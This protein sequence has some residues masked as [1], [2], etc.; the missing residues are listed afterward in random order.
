[1][2]CNIF[3]YIGGSDE[4]CKIFDL[5]NRVEHGQ[6]MHHEVNEPILSYQFFSSSRAVDP[7]SFFTD[8]A[9]LRNPGPALQNGDVTFF[10][11]LVKITVPPYRTVPLPFV[12]FAV[13][14]PLSS[15]KKIAHGAGPNLL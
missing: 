9:V 12:E 1:M 2:F 7:H 3:I 13:T 15:E 6:L 10:E 5:V 14:D 11:T 8:S 4:I